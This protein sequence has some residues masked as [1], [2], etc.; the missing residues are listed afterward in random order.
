M[1]IQI[2]MQ[3]QVRIQIQIQTNGIIATTVGRETAA[4]TLTRSSQ[5]LNNV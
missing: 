3:I 4:Q 5:T 2:Q 1:Y